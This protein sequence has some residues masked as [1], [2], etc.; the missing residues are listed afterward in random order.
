MVSSEN[1][2]N[3]RLLSTATDMRLPYCLSR[4][5]ATVLEVK[6]HRFA[7]AQPPIKRHD[8]RLRPMQNHPMKAASGLR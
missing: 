8:G 2:V 5:T 6:S 3:R 1:T 7:G 4:I